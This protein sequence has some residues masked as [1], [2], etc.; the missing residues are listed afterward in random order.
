MG[1][2]LKDM[3][4]LYENI[5]E[6]HLREGNSQAEAPRQQQACQVGRTR[7]QPSS[8]ECGVNG[9]DRVGP[10]QRGWGGCSKRGVRGSCDAGTA[11]YFT[12]NVTVFYLHQGER[13]WAR[14][15]RLRGQT[16]SLPL[17]LCF[18]QRRRLP[19]WQWGFITSF[20]GPLS[21]SGG[22]PDGPSQVAPAF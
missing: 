18:P 20:S 8:G 15:R 2:G 13:A 12:S 5:R 10:A 7:R 16:V 11:V 17:L 22:V 1:F 21:M 19:Q 14:V 3:S 4:W 6:E 9:A